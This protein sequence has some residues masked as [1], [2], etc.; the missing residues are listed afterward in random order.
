MCIRLTHAFASHSSLFSAQ[1]KNI[2]V[3][4]A[5][6]F[7]RRD[8]G[9]APSTSA[10]G[11]AAAEQQQRQQAAT[12]SPNASPTPST[13][14]AASP[15]PRAAARARPP[16][17][18]PLGASMSFNE[19]DDSEEDDGGNEAD[20][21]MAISEGGEEKG[22]LAHNRATKTALGQAS[23]RHTAPGSVDFCAI[24]SKRFTVTAYT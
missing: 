3:Q 16:P 11:A 13:S 6:R 14:A 20:V 23:Y 5:N 12:A 10:M 4:N 1:S 17:R 15:A 21:S 8:Q 22:S 19:E 24:C 7:R 2:R 18:R 9:E